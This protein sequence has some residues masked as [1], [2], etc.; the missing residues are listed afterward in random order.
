MSWTG[1][2]DLATRRF[3]KL[4]ILDARRTRSF[5]RATTETTIDVLFKRWRIPLETTFM[6]GAHQIDAATRTVI[7]VAGGDI[8]WTRFKTQPA[9]NASENFFLFACEY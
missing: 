1:R 6:N 2:C 3:Q 7:L 4:S 5:A 8:G 9:M